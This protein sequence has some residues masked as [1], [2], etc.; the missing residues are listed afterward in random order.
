MGTRFAVG[1]GPARVLNPER[2]VA[3]HAAW[4]AVVFPRRRELASLVRLAD[5]LLGE[6]RSAAPLTID[7]S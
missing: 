2:G 4:V 7:I 1:R 3:R 6:Y 5:A